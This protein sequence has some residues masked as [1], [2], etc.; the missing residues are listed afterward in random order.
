MLRACSKCPLRHWL[1][2][3]KL[4]GIEQVLRVER[5]LDRAHDS[6][7]AAMFRIEEIQFA[8]PDS[9]FARACAAHR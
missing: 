8:E 3:D 9:V 5:V 6:Y 1:Y 2:P 7:G 4:A